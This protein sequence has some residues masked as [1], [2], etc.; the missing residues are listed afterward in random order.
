MKKKSI[1]PKYKYI[2]IC[3]A[4]LLQFLLSVDVDLTMHLTDNSDLSESGESSSNS[5]EEF[6]PNP[7]QM[8]DDDLREEYIGMKETRDLVNSPNNPESSQLQ[9][10]KDFTEQRI[11]DL[12]EELINRNLY[13][14]E[15]GESSSDNGSVFSDDSN[16]S[17]NNE[18]NSPSQPA[19]EQSNTTEPSN[20][21]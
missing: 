11:N 21:D 1:N 10:L 16:S 14:T 9:L 8:T 3:V 18:Q 13:S 5:S 19:A 17:G 15:S 20:N 6:P 7:A 12:R 2:F 4:L